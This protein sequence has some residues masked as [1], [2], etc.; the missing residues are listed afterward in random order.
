MDTEVPVFHGQLSIKSEALTRKNEPFQKPKIYG[1]Q[2]GVQ[3][4]HLDPA[5]PSPVKIC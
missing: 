4:E 1:L 5:H 3:I 2:I